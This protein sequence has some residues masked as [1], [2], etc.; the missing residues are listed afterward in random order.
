ML[1]SVGFPS[2]WAGSACARPVSTPHRHPMPGLSWTLLKRRHTLLSALAPPPYPLPQ[3]LGFF[4]RCPHPRVRRELEMSPKQQGCSSRATLPSVPAV[5]CGAWPGVAGGSS[6]RIF[7]KCMDSV[8]SPLSRG[9]WLRAHGLPFLESPQPAGHT[10]MNG[11]HPPALFPSPAHGPSS[12]PTSCG[13]ILGLVRPSDT[14]GVAS[15]SPAQ[16]PPCHQQL[17]SLFFSSGQSS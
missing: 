1:C 6:A 2:S 14:H 10:H 7:T 17:L 16:T 4:C 3:G 13:C 5:T 12:L 15:V 9:P 8:P 11:H